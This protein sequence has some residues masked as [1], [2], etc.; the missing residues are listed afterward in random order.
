MTGYLGHFSSLW[1]MIIA[2]GILD[3]A[4]SSDWGLKGIFGSQCKGFSLTPS[5]SLRDLY[6]ITC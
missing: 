1:L 6:N 5:I 2:P 4:V 3:H